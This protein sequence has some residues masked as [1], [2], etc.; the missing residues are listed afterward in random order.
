L[1]L[2]FRTEGLSAGRDKKAGSSDL[3]GEAEGV[4]W[5]ALEHEQPRL[6]AVGRMRLIDRG[7]VLVGTIRSDGTPR[8]SPV[9][10]FLLDGTL[11]LSMMLGSTKAR[12]LL[13]DPRILVHSVITSRDGGEGEVKIRGVAQAEQAP[14]IQARYATA[15]GAALGWTPEPGRF[16]LFAVD[17]EH[18]TFVE[19]S[20]A[21]GGQ[22]V[23]M[24]PPAREFFRRNTSATSVGPPEPVTGPVWTRLLG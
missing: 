5:S 3:S 20:E 19:Y 22:H 17:I 11:W 24:W 15:V 12:D 7:V 10:P 23:A 18:V 16:H 21:A 13:R 9:E 1:R 2:T 4:D 6:A 14:Q 8:I